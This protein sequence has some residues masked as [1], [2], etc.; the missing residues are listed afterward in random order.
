MGL[1]QYTAAR[2]KAENLGNKVI[3]CAALQLLSPSEQHIDISAPGLCG[4]RRGIPALGSWVMSP[5]RGHAPVNLL[6]CERG[7][8]E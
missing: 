2:P 4:G 5:M 6:V 1:V 7:R 3:D 8:C